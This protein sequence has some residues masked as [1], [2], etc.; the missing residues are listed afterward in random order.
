[1]E[2]QILYSLKQEN[3]QIQSES[4]TYIQNYQTIL[5]L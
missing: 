3:Y 2:S 4:V 1:M 5:V